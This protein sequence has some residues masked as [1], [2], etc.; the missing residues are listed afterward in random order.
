MKKLVLLA[1][2]L[3]LSAH[4]EKKT[5]EQYW[6]ETGLTTDVVLNELHL[7]NASSCGKDFNSYRGCIAAVNAVAAMSDPALRLVPSQALGMGGFGKV[8]KTFGSFS[9]AQVAEEKNEDSFRAIWERQ[10][11][12]RHAA[13]DSAEKLFKAGRE[14]DFEPIFREVKELSVKDSKLDAAAAA[15]AV[16]GFLQ[17]SVDSHARIEARAA[18]Y[19]SMNDADQS[20]VG[21]GIV[22]QSLGGKTIV[23]NPVEGGPADKAGIKSNDVVTKV[24]G[25][26]VE[27]AKLGKV[28]D[29]VRGPKGKRVVLTVK[30]DGR[31]FPVSIVRDQISLPNVE[32]KTVSDLGASVGVIKLRNFMDRNACRMM[33]QEIREMK[34]VSGLVLDLRGNGGGLIDQAVCIGGLFLGQKVVVKVKDLDQ[35]SF[36]SL[37]AQSP[38]VTDLPLVVL[39]D[40]G[41]ASASEI[42]S[43]AIQDHQR[44]WLL[45]ERSFGKGTVQANVN[46]WNDKIVFYRTIQRFYQPS[47]RTNQQVG[48]SPDFEVPATP[49]ASEDVRFR[50]READIFPH[51][52]GAV[53][54]S[55]VQPRPDEV[56]R[57]N[58]CVAGEKLADKVFA[59]A[60]AQGHAADY[61]LL[62]AEETLRCSR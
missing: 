6:T 60:K 1:L 40:A 47:G 17:D 41:S 57:V 9:L 28:V 26:S 11:A 15:A 32:S 46:F 16:T 56:T 13:E 61:Q 27:G 20:F 38:A 14:M 62:S 10:E 48:I 31:N 39:I 52:L 54:P 19:D 4:A 33:E 55:W 44:G 36:E 51:G 35:D 18:L 24:D 30:R 5:P 42:V 3:S 2:F 49:G 59:E 43:G 22:L 50:L 23:I 58:D 7:L 21:V 34:S 29:L 8:V 53:G 25:V 45:G 37:P 12:R